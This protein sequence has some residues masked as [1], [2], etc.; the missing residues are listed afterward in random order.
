[1]VGCCAVA[2][3]N[4]RVLPQGNK[5]QHHCVVKRLVNVPIMSSAPNMRSKG[6]APHF[7][8]ACWMGHL[9]K[10]HSLN[11]PSAGLQRDNASLSWWLCVVQLLWPIGG[12]C[13][14]GTNC[15]SSALTCCTIPKCQLVHGEATRQ[16]SNHELRPNMRSK[17]CAPHFHHAWMGH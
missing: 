11:P 13:R 6:C 10:R 17:E 7:L 1:M 4:W 12:R 5:L 14:K 8:H 16:C 15:S 9:N 3:A 2:V